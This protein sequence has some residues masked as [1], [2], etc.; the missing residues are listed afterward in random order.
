MAAPFA[1]VAVGAPAAAAPTSV[2]RVNAGGAAAPSLD[3]GP[4]WSGDT[5]LAPSPLT[6]YLEA[7]STTILADSAVTPLAGMPA[8]VLDTA[9]VGGAEGAPMAWTLPAPAGLYELRLYFA[10]IDPSATATGARVFDVSVNGA[11]VL[12]SYDVSAEAGV[13]GMES[14]S[15]E[16]TGEIEVTFTSVSGLPPLLNGLELL[17]MAP[18]QVVAASDSVDLGTVEVGSTSSETVLL[19]NAGDVDATIGT[20]DVPAP[21]STDASPGL[22]VPAGGSTSITVTFAPTTSGAAAASLTLSHDGEGGSAVIALN[23]DTPATPADVSA[24]PASADLG[25]AAIGTVAEQT[26]RLGNTGGTDATVVSAE[27]TA[28]FAVELAAGTV[29]PA[30]GAVDMTVTFT[31]ADEGLAAGTATVMLDDGSDV[32]VALAATGLATPSDDPVVAPLIAVADGEV[33]ATPSSVDLGDVEVGSTGDVTVTLDNTGSGDATVTSVSLSAPFSTDAVVGLTVPAGGSTDI[34]VSVAPTAAGAISDTLALGFEGA[35]STL[36]IPVAAAGI[37]PPAPDAAVSLL[38]STSANRSGATELEGKII[39]GNAYVFTGPD[40]GVQSV[41]FY[42]DDPD[43]SGNAFHTENLAPFD[44]VNTAGNGNG[45]AWNTATLADGTH[46]ITALVTLSGGAGTEV[47]TATFTIDNPDPV[48]GTATLQHSTSADRSAPA[49]LDGATVAGDAYIF[50]G[51]DTGVQ[52]VAFWLDN[53]TRSGNP[54]HTENLAPFDLVNTAGNGNGTAWDTTGVANGSHTVSAL[55]QYSDGSTDVLL[56]TFTVDNSP[57]VTASPSSLAFGSLAVGESSSLT[58]SLTNGSA[59]AATLSSVAVTAPFSTSATAGLTIPAGATVDIDV[60]FAPTASGSSAATLTI[61]HDGGAPVA[62]ALSGSATG[63]EPSAYGLSTSENPDRSASENLDGATVTGNAYIFAGPTTGVTQ[64]AFWLDDPT[65]SGGATHTENLAPFDFVNTA[66][67]GNGTAWNSAGVIDGT[68]TITARFVVSGGAVEIVTATFTVDNPDPVPGSATLL[69]STSTDRSAPESLDGA[70]L[71]GDAFV[72]IGSDAGVT[73]AAFW[74]DNPAMS[75]GATHTENLAPFDF[76]NTGGGGNATAWDTTAIASGTHTISAR[77]TYA[78]G[79]V[80]VLQATFAIGNGSFLIAD[81]SS[82]TFVLEPGGAAQQSLVSVTTSDGTSP[83]IGATASP[84]GSWLTVTANPGTTPASFTIAAD[85]SA[86]GAG[87]H[88]GT[89]TFTAADL[90]STVVQVN[91]SVGGSTT[92]CEPLECSEI[93]VDLPYGLD[94]SENGGKLLDGNGFGTGFT[95]VLPTS[96]GTGYIPENIEVDPLPVGELVLTTTAGLPQGT[97]DNLDNALGVGIDAPDQITSLTTTLVDLDGGGGSYQQAGLWFG[98]DE[99]NYVKFVAV[100]T[101]TALELEVAVEYNG[102]RMFTANTAPGGLDNIDVHLQLVADPVTR[103][104]QAQYWIGPNEVIEVATFEIPGEFFSFDAAGTDP[105]I[106]TRTFGGIFASHRNAGS[107]LTYRFADFVVEEYAEPPA[108]PDYP[109]SRVSTAVTMPTSMV[110]GPDD[111]L[112]VTEVFGKIHALTFD[113]GWN[114]IADEVISTIG[115][116][117]TLGITTDPASTPTDVI[118]WVAHSDPTFSDADPNTG[119][120]SR[121]S[122]AGFTTRQDVITGLPRAEADHSTNSLH[123]GPDGLL[124]FAQGGNTGAG[125]PNTT[126]SEFGDRPEQPLSAALLVADV[127]D[128][129]FQGSCATPLGD[130]ITDTAANFEIPTT[131]DVQ[132]FATGLRNMYDFTFHS[133]GE[134]YGP[135]NALGVQG[136]YPVI[137]ADGSCTGLAPWPTNDPGTQPD[138]LT[139]LLEGG[140]YGHPNPYREECVFFSG[141]EQGVAPEPDYEPAIYSFGNNRSSNGII[142]YQGDSFCGALSGELLV[143]S[144][145]VGDNI[146][147]LQLSP[148]GNSILQARVMVSGFDDPLPIAQGPDGVIFVGEFGGG[149]VTTLIPEDTGC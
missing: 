132:L 116:R 16:S 110:W 122:G 7:Q 148:D 43:M 82:L 8:G 14:L 40:T 39:A 86:L 49:A 13:G 55:V 32:I 52:S 80:Q 60:T 29:I 113:S 69:H 21:F 67:N 92:V 64:V 143:T 45:T 61:G 103:L 115:N 24:A 27:A 48:P 72:F 54:T 17:A 78:D 44:L 18:A 73:Q 10:E 5:E 121:L 36:D 109:F 77:V 65:M 90:T 93:L 140:Y 128:P 83:T 85:P 30:G 144:Y 62:I 3:D 111:R 25:E 102:V 15:V 59:S 127:K 20:V 51:P 6:N 84:S 112:Y 141:E 70:T 88:V 19:S 131:C 134:M 149:Q 56:A 96:N 66:G 95:Y 108:E 87:L 130:G 124:Y 104:M 63:G 74:L 57:S 91:A 4:A 133:N 76:V 50:T 38:H 147:R 31:P 58:V 23:G 12:S 145:S 1:I 41:A 33:D 2:L 114:V 101:P 136:T 35:A 137:Q 47:A 34:T 71:S 42:V 119:M 142:E 107:P 68:H 129:T 97:L 22:T 53:P 123:F 100:N 138:I 139:H 146:T 9:R 117:L 28:P 99:D 98:N 106:G 46:T 135:T 126:A 105:A 81:P 37:D 120:V 94:F 118:L 26:V 89:V 11:T 75:G 125:A 79:S